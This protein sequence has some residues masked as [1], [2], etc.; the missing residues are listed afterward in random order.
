MK[1]LIL[2]IIIGASLASAVFYF[3]NQR[4]VTN[5]KE[6]LAEIVELLKQGQAKRE[7]TKEA[8][9]DPEK[10]FVVPA[11]L[12]IIIAASDEYFYFRDN[13]CSKLE[14]TGITGINTLLNEEMKNSKPCDLMILIKMAP[15][16]TF[17]NSIALLDII[18]KTGIP[19]GHFAE[20]EISENEKNCLQNY[21]KN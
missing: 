7:Q 10:S 18:S 14:K 15:G 8:I 12:N 9:N 4:E 1:K 3:I 17:K 11:A 6:N 19:P 13:D 5:Q 20:I 2:G 21:K 16:S